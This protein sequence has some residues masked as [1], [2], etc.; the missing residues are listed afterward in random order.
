MPARVKSTP[1]A[2]GFVGLGFAGRGVKA[3]SVDNVHPDRGTVS[4]GRYALARPLF[5]FTNGYPKIGS[6][7]HTFVT[8]YLTPKGQELIESLGFVPVTQ[9]PSKGEDAAEG[10]DQE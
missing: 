3:V 1:A 8:F 4:T 10:K 5:M 9:Y 6:P 7:L 2:V